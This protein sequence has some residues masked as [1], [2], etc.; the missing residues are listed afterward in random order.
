VKSEQKI[1]ATSGGFGGILSDSENFGISAAT[2]G[3]LDGD[4][5]GDL[6]VGASGNDDAGL[7]HGAVWIRFL[8]AMLDTTA[9]VLNCPSSVI[10]ECQNPNGR[11]VQFT[12]TATDDFDPAPGLVCVPPSPSFFPN[13]TT[14]VTCTATDFSGNSSTCTFD[15]IVRD[16]TPPTITCPLDITVR[17]PKATQEVPVTFNVTATDVC[18]ASP[19]IVCV[20]PSGSLFRWGTTTVTCTATD[21]SGNSRICTFQVVVQISVKQF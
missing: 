2:L 17:A 10:R 8:D 3:D 4:G 11:V 14:P 15:V 1:S 19:T 12:V 18:D 7:N 13:G 5:K 6:A 20:P 21:D 16:T 9:P